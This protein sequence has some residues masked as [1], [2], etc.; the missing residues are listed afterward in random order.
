MKVNVELMTGA[1]HTFEVK[2]S[3]TIADVKKKLQDVLKIAPEKQYLT[4]DGSKLADSR[5]LCE[6]SRGGVVTI[7]LMPS[8]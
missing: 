7:G 8:F 2:A 6:L 5:P 3:G 4:N 1:T